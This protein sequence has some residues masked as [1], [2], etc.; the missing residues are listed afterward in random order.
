M[1][2]STPSEDEYSKF[3][4]WAGLEDVNFPRFR[5]IYVSSNNPIVNVITRTG[6]G[7]REYYE[8]DACTDVP[9]YISDKDMDY[10]STYAKFKYKILPKYVD[11]WKNHVKEE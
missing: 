7:N 2:N 3:T 8:N 1:L 6:G 11:E 10:D 5:D 9:T 4:R